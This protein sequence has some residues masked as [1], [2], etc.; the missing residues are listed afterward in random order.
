VKRKGRRKSVLGVRCSEQC[1]DLGRHLSGLPSL[2]AGKAAHTGCCPL[3]FIDKA[4]R[5][6][7]ATRGDGDGDAIRELLGAEEPLSAKH[8]CAD[9]DSTGA[10]GAPK[11]DLV[12]FTG[13]PTADIAWNGGRGPLFLLGVS[14]CRAGGE[15]PLSSA[16]PLGVNIPSAG[17]VAHDGRTAGDAERCTCLGCCP[18]R[19]PLEENRDGER[20][21]ALIAAQ[22]PAPQIRAE[23]ERHEETGEARTL[24]AP[25]RGVS[26]RPLD[27]AAWKLAQELRAAKGSEFCTERLLGFSCTT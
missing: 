27:T 11:K 4:A 15:H 14:S 25:L 17:D 8:S 19:R 23:H 21:C 6:W 12:A 22:Q 26:D 16:L 7:W 9:G 18:R 5:I 1:V 13:P 24:L 3:L 20:E 2:L 10:P